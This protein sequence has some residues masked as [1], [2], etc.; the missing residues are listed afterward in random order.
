MRLCRLTLIVC[1]AALL[2]ACAGLPPSSTGPAAA[3]PVSAA[4]RSAELDRLQTLLRDPVFALDMAQS[5]D[6]AYYRGQGQTPPP[7]LK[8]EELTATTPKSMREEKIAIN[9]A[10]FYALETGA[11]Y[12]AERDRQPLLD[13]L[14]AVADGRRPDADMLLLARF[15]NATWKAGQPFR[16]LARI[17]RPAFVPAARLD[18]VELRKDFAQ[19]R[20]AATRLVAAMQDSRG[21]DNAAQLARLQALLRD[22]TFAQD[23]AQTLDA[24]YYTGQ[25]QPVPPFLKPEE[26]SAT[27]PKSVREEKIAMNL[28]GFYAL[29]A[30]VGI[31][32]E[33]GRESPLQIIDGVAQG[34]RPASDML[35][36]A[37]LANATWK[38]GQPFRSLARISRDTFKPAALLTPDDVAKD[39]AQIRAAAVRLAQAMRQ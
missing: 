4:A 11:G 23:M 24:A 39:H 8:P 26:M 29:E 18:A 12:L 38:A 6:A 3:P 14:Q 10:G 2:A 5:L 32:A 9:L 22:T 21:R 27:A 31:I 13:V 36:L 15:A 7:F 25:G 20:A 37:R 17:S 33:R 35:L 19:I 16:A 1:A 28:A 34:T 30:G